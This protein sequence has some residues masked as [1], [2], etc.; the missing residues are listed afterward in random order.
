LAGGGVSWSWLEPEQ[1]LTPE[2]Q[3][4]SAIQQLHDI[5]QI[6]GQEIL[7][8]P[9]SRPST[10][11]VDTNGVT[12]WMLM[13]AKEMQSGDRSGS[14]QPNTRLG[15]IAEAILDRGAVTE[16]SRWSSAAKTTGKT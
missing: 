5:V 10:K 11:M 8:D 2:E 1:V 13:V 4:A 3:L 9:D 16:I 6:S 7:S 14:W 15:V 12:L